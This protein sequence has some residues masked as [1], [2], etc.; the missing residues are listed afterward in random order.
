VEALTVPQT[1]PSPHP[2]DAINPALRAAVE[3]CP[4]FSA[5]H[6]AAVLFSAAAIVAV[7]ATAR[8]VRPAV[9]PTGSP[10]VDPAGRVLGSLALVHWAAYQAWWNLPIRFSLGDS[11][12]LHVCD[13]TGLACGFALLTGKQW[14]TA[15]TY[16]WGLALSTQAFV[17]PTVEWGPT[18][19]EFWLFWE[20]HT[21]IVG[22]AAYLVL[23]RNFRPTVRDLCLAYLSLVGYAAITLPMDLA[24]GWN[25]GYIGGGSPSSATLIDSLGSWPWRLL[26]M[27]GLTLLAML[28]LWLPWAIVRR[29]SGAAQTAHPLD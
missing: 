18:Y 7:I 26:P 12:P 14:L 20:T 3:F 9:I 2:N 23:V 29:R 6:L 4:P 5:A 15:I 22:G 19:T 13:L 17:T 16:F 10:M 21:I 24:T 11:L 8:W 27:A 25:Y 1:S 28:L